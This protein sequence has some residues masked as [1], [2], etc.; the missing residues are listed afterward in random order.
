MSVTLMPMGPGVLAGLSFKRRITARFADGSTVM[1]LGIPSVVDLIK[2]MPGGGVPVAID[3]A[4][5]TARPLAEQLAVEAGWVITEQQ[6]GQFYLTRPGISA[7]ALQAALV[8]APPEFM[9]DRPVAPNPKSKTRAQP[10]TS[11]P[12]LSLGPYDVFTDAYAALE[13]VVRTMGHQPLSA[14]YY[15]KLTQTFM[16]GGFEGRVRSLFR[17]LPSE[18]AILSFGTGDGGRFGCLGCGGLPLDAPN[19]PLPAKAQA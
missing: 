8:E 6:Q 5:D 9:E 13:E 3:T 11:K 14:N 15:N 2:A 4:I 17:D 7:A 18:P 16:A 1:N 19:G 12:F 10:R